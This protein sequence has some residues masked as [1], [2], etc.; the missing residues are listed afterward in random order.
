MSGPPMADAWVSMVSWLV[1]AAAGSWMVWRELA[2]PLRVARRQAV[3]A[4]AWGERFARGPRAGVA[5]RCQRRVAGL[6]ATGLCAAVGW[7]L[8]LWLTHP[9]LS[10]AVRLLTP[11]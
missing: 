6:V 3:A 4:R 7:S 11:A 5:L 2:A 10:L 1:A 9:G 8:L